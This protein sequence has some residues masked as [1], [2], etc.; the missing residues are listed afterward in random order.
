MEERFNV[1]LNIN[2]VFHRVENIVEEEINAGYQ[3]F[4]L[5]PQCFDKAYSSEGVKSYSTYGGSK[6]EIFRPYIELKLCV[7][8]TI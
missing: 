3:H 5:L 1:T 7:N 6:E 2:L 8:E 4:L